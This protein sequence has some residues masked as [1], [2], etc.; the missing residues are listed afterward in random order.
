[1]NTRNLRLGLSLLGCGV[2]ALM[3]NACSPTNFDSV[4]EG[5]GSIAGTSGVP[6]ANPADPV[7]CDPFGDTGNGSATGGL[8]GAI[9]EWSLSNGEPASSIDM[10]QRG[11]KLAANLFLTRVYAP[12]RSFTAGFGADNGQ[13]LKNEKGETLIEWFG[14]NLESQLKLGASDDLG[15]YQIALI[16][17][18]GSTLAIADSKGQFNNLIENDGQ[19]ATQMACAKSTVSMNGKAVRVPMHLT[20]YQGPRQEIAMVMMWR[21]IPSGGSLDEEQC[22]RSGVNLFWD[23]SSQ[24][25][26]SVYQAMLSRGWKPMQADNFELPGNQTNLCNR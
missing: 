25:P 11:R 22:G 3:G 23:R 2:A 15:D 17:D 12:T 5:K 13:A 9:Y 21:K 14:L 18:D 7:V 4:P 8:R 16:S 10:I 6:G 19:H 1:M 26:S 24:Q 20:Y